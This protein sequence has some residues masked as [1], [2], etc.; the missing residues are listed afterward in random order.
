MTLKECYEE[1]GGN[2]ENVMERM[3]SEAFVLKFV[4]KFLKDDS[5]P[6][7]CEAMNRGDI[8]G[9]FRA[10]HTL[11][12]ICQ[13]LAFTKLYESSYALTEL[14]RPRTPVDAEAAM[15]QVTEDYQRMITAIQKLNAEN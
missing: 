14:L 1:F 12:G 6:A 15:R 13:N 11:K 5:Y 2:Y 7:L 9:A 8:E 3:P 4:K 10:V